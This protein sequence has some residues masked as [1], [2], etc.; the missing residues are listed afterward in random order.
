MKKKRAHVNRVVQCLA[1]LPLVI[2]L[3]AGGCLCT[4]SS[5]QV[6]EP[7]SLRHP[8]LGRSRGHGHPAHRNGHGG[9]LFRQRAGGIRHPAAEHL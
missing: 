4:G 3:G 9:A 6:E 1:V 5:R 7:E 8:S 2:V